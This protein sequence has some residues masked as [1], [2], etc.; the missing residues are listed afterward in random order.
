MKELTIQLFKYH[1]WANSRMVQHLKVLPKE[2]FTNQVDSVFP[3]ISY[4][5]G[6]I[7]AVDEL[8]YLRMKKESLKQMVPKLFLTIEEVEGTCT[9]LYQE[10]DEFLENTGD[11]EQVVIYKNTEGDV[12]NNSIFEIVQ[13]IVNHGTYHRGNIAAMIRQMGYEGIGTDYIYYL[14]K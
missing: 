1:V 3:T 4:A 13:H 2:I 5:F 14:R 11:V 10:I 12:F 9:G 7:I 8:W 6:H